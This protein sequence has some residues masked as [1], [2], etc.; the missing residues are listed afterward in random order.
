MKHLFLLTFLGSVALLHADPTPG[1]LVWTEV[2]VNPNGITQGSFCDYNG[3]GCGA[4]GLADRSFS[5]TSAGEF[6]L[7]T[8]LDADFEGFNCGNMRGCS[9]DA[10]ASGTAQDDSQLF[11]SP[12]GVDV[13]ASG[14]GMSD[15]VC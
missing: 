15:S 1:S 10:M 5:V 6:I 8:S 4:S 13:F 11:N 9:P 7:T 3:G 12:T 14:S 2:N